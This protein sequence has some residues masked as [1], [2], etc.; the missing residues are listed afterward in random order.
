MRRKVLRGVP[1]GWKSVAATA[2]L[3]IKTGAEANSSILPNGPHEIF[4]IW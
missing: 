3:I 1:E 4:P 2:A